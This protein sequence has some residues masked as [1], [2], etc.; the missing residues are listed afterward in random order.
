Y[1]LANT[2]VDW[3][4]TYARAANTLCLLDMHQS[5]YESY[6]QTTLANSD[7]VPGQLDEA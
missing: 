3:A 5:A 1:I 7:H 4:H 6:C 2:I